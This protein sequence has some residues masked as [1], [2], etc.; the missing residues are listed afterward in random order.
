[1][2]EQSESEIDYVVAEADLYEVYSLLADAT[3]A[4]AT[5]DTNECASKASD[6]KK[7]LKE[8]HEDG[9]LLHEVDHV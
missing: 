6:A 8:V 1:M 5:G 7:K 2:S 3:D 9:D 4:A